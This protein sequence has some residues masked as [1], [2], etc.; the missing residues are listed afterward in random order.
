MRLTIRRIKLDSQG[1]DRHGRYYGVGDRLYYCPE[2]S[3]M[4]ALTSVYYL[5]PDECRAND[6][7]EARAIFKARMERM[8]RPGCKREVTP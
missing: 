3:E 6:L 7:Q 8:D 1:Y 4:R 2:V 5:E